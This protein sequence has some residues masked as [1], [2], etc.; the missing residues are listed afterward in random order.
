MPDAIVDGRLCLL[1]SDP[2]IRRD[3]RHCDTHV[4][5]GELFEAAQGL[6]RFDRPALVVWA[7]EDLMTPRDH[8]RRLT[9]LLPQGRLV[10]VEDT[11]TLIAEDQPELLTSLP[12]E[13]VAGKP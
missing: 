9:E 6:R 1:R 8:G 2:A 13:F 11:R 12:R 5:R 10:E 4:R 7:L 3:F